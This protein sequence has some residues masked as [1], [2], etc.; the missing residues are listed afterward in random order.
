MNKNLAKA[1]ALKSLNGIAIDLAKAGKRYQYGHDHPLLEGDDQKV[2]H[3]SLLYD[4]VSNEKKGKSCFNHSLPQKKDPHASRVWGFFAE[5]LSVLKRLDADPETWLSAQMDRMATWSVVKRNS[6]VPFPNMLYGEGA[7]KRYREY[8]RFSEDATDAA[9]SRTYAEERMD[10][11]EVWE[12]PLNLAQM[13]ELAIGKGLVIDEEL[14]AD[15]IIRTPGMFEAEY[16]VASPFLRLQIDRSLPDETLSD[17]C[18]GALY[19]M[20]MG[21]DKMAE[22]SEKYEKSVVEALKSVDTSLRKEIGK[23]L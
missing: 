13:L 14:V 3:L 21:R 10:L 11:V 5:W 4:R 18:R 16:V 22:L 9:S 2:F 17:Y 8:L 23:W 20:R 12:G 6:G 19:Q 7:V 15:M 1:T